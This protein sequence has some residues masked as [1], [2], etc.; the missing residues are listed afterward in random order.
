MRQRI[1]RT[2]AA[3]SGLLLLLLA[4]AHAQVTLE[5]GSSLRILHISD[6]HHHPNG[7][8]H[9]S[10]AGTACTPTNTTAFL[11]SAIAL[12]RPDLIIFMGDTVD[13]ESAPLKGA[14]DVT[15]S[16]AAEANTP[17]AAILGNH[18]DQLEMGREEILRYVM[19]FGGSLTQLGPVAGSPGNYYIDLRTACSATTQR[20]QQQQQQVPLAE[21]CDDEPLARLVF[22]DSR[23]EGVD[24]SVNDAQLEWL[25]GLPRGVPTLAYHHIPDTA[26]IEAAGAVQPSDAPPRKGWRESIDADRPNPAVFPSL[27]EVGTIAAFAGHDHT[28]DFCAAHEAVQLCYVGSAGYTAYGNCQPDKE[29]CVRRRVRVVELGLRDS[30]SG[31]APPRFETLR[32]WLREADGAGLASSRRVDDRE[33][34]HR[35][36]R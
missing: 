20:Q 5:V 24:Q 28:N 26:Y 29:R 9:D 14:M 11:R 25:R 17:F 7:E 36:V 18:E 16:L 27:R 15:Y 23:K 34:W 6:L 13:S 8:C 1:D 30:S 19:G 35:P 3:R 12:E 2:M 10:D 22:V 33:L 31:S 32:S 21:P 4:S